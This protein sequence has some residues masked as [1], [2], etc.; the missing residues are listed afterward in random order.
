MLMSN[1]MHHTE[2]GKQYNPAY[3][4]TVTVLASTPWNSKLN[5]GNILETTK[6]F[7]I[8]EKHFIIISQT[9]KGFS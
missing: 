8:T 4:C 9:V 7:Y 3:Q 1:C 5:C 2:V 6:S